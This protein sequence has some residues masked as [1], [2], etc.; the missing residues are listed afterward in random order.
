MRHHTR[1]AGFLFALAPFV[2]AAKTVTP[3]VSLDEALAMSA[4]ELA[5]TC[6]RAMNSRKYVELARTGAGVTI[7]HRRV[8]ARNADEVAAEIDAQLAVCR[9]A[10]TQRGIAQ[11]GGT[12]AGTATGCER[13]QS[14]LAEA[15]G[16]AGTSV[17]FEQDGTALGITVSGKLKDGADFSFPAPGTVVENYIAVIDPGNSDYVLKGDA[18]DT[19]ISLRPDTKS[20]LAAWPNWAGPP[21]AEELASCVIYL[22]RTLQNAPAAVAPEAERRGGEGR[23]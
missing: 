2:L 18:T 7:G 23:D 21:K 9:D 3:D 13:A 20:V 16:L 5:A 6:N 22:Q 1:L 17:R 12:W 8:T 15:L 19:S 10:I 11:V 14:L 4:A